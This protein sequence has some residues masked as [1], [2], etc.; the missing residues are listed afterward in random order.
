[1][2]TTTVMIN[3]AFKYNEF[4]PF[5]IYG[6]Y[7]YG[8]TSYSIKVLSELYGKYDENGNLVEP[9]YD[10]NVLSKHFVMHPRDFINHLSRLVNNG[11]REKCLV[12]DDAGLWLY[13]LDWFNPFVKGVSKY[14]NVA[15]THFASIIFTTPTPQMILKKIRG[16]PDAIAVRIQKADNDQYECHRVK[17]YAV[18]YLW[19]ISPDG[20]KSGVRTVFQD[21]FSIMLPD[22]VYNAYCEMRRKYVAWAVELLKRELEAFEKG[23]KLVK[24]VEVSSELLEAVKNIGESENIEF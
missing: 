16:L 18:G 8:K 13:A 19:W 5:I 1:M 2:F 15:R 12:C 7:G 14:L 23:G 3:K 4:K 9:C 6:P 20:K 21:Q 17:R 22:S 11:G 10:W 24:K